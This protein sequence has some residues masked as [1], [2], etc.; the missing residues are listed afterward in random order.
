MRKLRNNSIL[1]KAIIINVIVVAMIVL[2][3]V[4]LIQKGVTSHDILWIGLIF[5]ISYI[6]YIQRMGKK[7]NL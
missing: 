3:I 1:L 4:R 6:F 2:I 7:S 5:F